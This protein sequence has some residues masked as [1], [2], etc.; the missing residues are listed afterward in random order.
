M[1]AHVV[2]NTGR[3]EWYTPPDYIEA[4]RRTMGE[5]DLDPASSHVAQLTVRAVRFYTAELD[6][7]LPANRWHGRVWMNPPYASKL[8][9]LFCRRL[10]V[11]ISRECVS[12]AI[13]LVNNAT[14]TAWFKLLSDRAEAICLPTGRVKFLTPEGKTGTPL[15]GQAIFYFGPNIDHFWA[16]FNGF[17]QIWTPYP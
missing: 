9:T 11:E 12:E 14:E 10:C 17:G 2:H 3:V 15:Q 8:I 7:L 1:T 5:I 6:G 13:V 4:A 16:N